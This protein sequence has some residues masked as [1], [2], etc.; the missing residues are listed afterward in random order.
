MVYLGPDSQRITFLASKFFVVS[1]LMCPQSCFE[2]IIPSLEVKISNNPR[3][4]SLQ[5][6]LF[7]GQPLLAVCNYKLYLIQ[8]GHLYER[9]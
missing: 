4:H 3:A 1:V 8:Q 7:E 6:T 5:F 9:K 2:E